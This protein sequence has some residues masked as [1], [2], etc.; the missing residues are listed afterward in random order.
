LKGIYSKQEHF[1]SN[2]IFVLQAMSRERVLAFLRVD[3][4]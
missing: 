1:H 4:F 2:Q 3:E